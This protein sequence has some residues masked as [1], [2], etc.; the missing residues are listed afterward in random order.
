MTDQSPRSVAKAPET[1]DDTERFWRTDMETREGWGFLPYLRHLEQNA[2]GAP[3]IGRNARLK[4]ELA[5]IGQDPFLSFPDA[6]LSHLGRAKNGKPVVRCRF[7]GYFGPQGA[8]PLNMTEEVMRWCIGGDTAFVDFADIFATRFIQLYY[9]TWSDGRAITQFDHP[10][11]YRFE[12]YLHAQAGLGSPAML[13]TGAVDDV[14]RLRLT[15]LTM[16][17][18]KSATKLRKM[19]EVHFKTDIEVEEMVPTWM[20]FEP[21]SLTRIGQQGSTL[22]RDIHLGSR[23]RSIS[24]KIRLHLRLPTLDRYRAFLPGQKN[25]AQLRDLVFTYLGKTLEVDVILWLP[26]GQIMPAKIGES[27]ELGYM[28]A[29]PESRGPEDPDEYRQAALFRLDPDEEMSIAA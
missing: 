25:H 20:N 12:Q 18:V 16:G 11:Q 13:G 22:G 4:D 28:A 15:P 14:H 5:L 9:R 24:E 17:R 8:L 23:V 26:A 1:P 27:A 19:L 7:M 29:L 6:N 21:D 2:R 3:P 10:D